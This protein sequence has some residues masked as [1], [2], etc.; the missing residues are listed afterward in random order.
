M[1]SH[2]VRLN[3]KGRL[4]LV[5][6]HLELGRSLKELAAE[7]GI[8]LR[9]ASRWLARSRSGG[10]ASLADRRSVRRSQRRTLDPQQL[11]QSVDHRHQR[12]TLRRIAKTL[13]APLAT[14]GKVMNALGL[15]RLW[16]LEPRKP[17]QRYQWERPGDMIHVDTKQLTRFELVGSGDV[18]SGHGGASPW[19]MLPASVIRPGW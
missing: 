16:N 17:V 3:Q 8:S 9:C 1:R 6:Q 19:A 13:K 10:P 7:N 15:G 12:C 2:P 5:T 14:V 4:R 18:E 11:Q